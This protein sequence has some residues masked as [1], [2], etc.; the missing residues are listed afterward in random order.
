MKKYV[1]LIVAL[2]AISIVLCACTKKSDEKVETTPPTET[3]D[4]GMLENLE[5]ESNT[6]ATTPDATGEI[7]ADWDIEVDVVVPET[8]PPVEYFTNDY[9]TFRKVNETVKSEANVYLRSSPGGAKVGAVK[10]GV[11]LTRVGIGDENGYSI[12]MYQDKEAYVAT[13]YVYPTSDPNY[14]EVNDV[15]VANKEANLRNGPSIKCKSLGKIAVG[16]ELIRTA[17][18]DDG[19]SKVQYKENT[20]YIYSLY[21]D[22]KDKTEDE[23]A[24]VETT[25]SETESFEEFVPE[26]ER[27]PVTENNITAPDEPQE[28]IPVS[29]L[30][31]YEEFGVIW[32]VVDETMEAARTVNVRKEPTTKSEKLG[33]VAGA[34][35]I[36]RIAVGDNG[37]SKVIFKGENAYIKSE[38]LIDP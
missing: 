19:W 24:V 36:Q 32:N 25:P 26:E 2:V 11:T 7:P 28:E 6:E 13:Y 3:S 15:V 22:P 21:V 30:T 33:Q 38:Y 8:E 12:V 37:W 17:I 9:G 27:A 20:A 14:T 4:V 23:P 18:G 35:T 5:I 1:K 29:Q 10:D 16:G 34:K 31:H